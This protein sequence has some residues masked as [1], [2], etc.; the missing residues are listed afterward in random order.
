MGKSKRRSDRRFIILCS[1]PAVVLY[2]LFMILP[3]M[4]VFRMSLYKWSGFSITKSFVG[5]DNFK[6]LI[7]DENFIKAFQNTI[8]LLVVV[9]IVTMGLALLLAALM[10]MEKLKGKSLYRFIIYIPN[11]LSIVVIAA[12]FSAIYDQKNGLLNNILGAFRLGAWKQ[13]WL[14]DQHI[15][16]YSIA[17]AMVWQSV[18]Y[19]MVMYA[20]SMASIPSSLYEAASLEGA[21]KIKQFFSITLPLIWY[22]VRNTLTFFIISS[23][24]LSF[25]LIKAMTNGGPDGSSEV[26]LSYMYKQAYTNSSYGYGMAIG[27]VIF[28]FSFALSLIVNKI[29]ERETL[30]Y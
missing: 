27:V 15:I 17:L 21:S 19:Y 10:S 20:S 12:I 28:V 11:V 22:S 23:I 8:L 6:I 1:M 5:L 13:V 4:N 25:V 16:I 30:H 24:N 7:A 2:V 18:G 14:G 29:T 3:T 9:T 26:L